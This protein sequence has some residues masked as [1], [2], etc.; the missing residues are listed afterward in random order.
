MEI[1]SSDSQL[2]EDEEEDGD[3]DEDGNLIQEEATLWFAGSV[4]HANAETAHT[5][6]HWKMG[7]LNFVTEQLERSGYMS[8]SQLAKRQKM[9][10]KKRHK[11][12]DEIVGKWETD[13]TIN[14]LHRAFKKTIEKA[15]EQPTTGRYARN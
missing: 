14:S 9:T 12:V 1:E 11:Q 10:P 7:L 4:C 6:I 15:R 3:E 2:D 8:P 5:L 13:G